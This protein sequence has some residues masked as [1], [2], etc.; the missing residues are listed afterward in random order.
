MPELCL[1]QGQA[2][3]SHSEFLLPQPVLTFSF[4]AVEGAG[5]AQC[6]FIESRCLLGALMRVLHTTRQGFK[7]C[8]DLGLVDRLPRLVCAQAQHAN[9]LYQAY[10]KV[11]RRLH[12]VL[13]SL[14]ASPVNDVAVA[15]VMADTG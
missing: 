13:M 4:G 6:L 3:G 9:P 8:K 7:M 14:K 5:P 12:Q 15:S 1:S 11:C 10:K 2:T